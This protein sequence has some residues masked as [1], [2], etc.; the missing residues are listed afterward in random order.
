MNTIITLAVLC[1]VLSVVIYIFVER[2]KFYRRNQSG[3]ETFPSYSRFV[4]TRIGEK[5]LKL[6]ALVL[7]LAGIGFLA[8]WYFNQFFWD[9]HIIFK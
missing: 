3:I 9:E 2:R 1:M 6:I 4:I 5:L 8:I 7:F